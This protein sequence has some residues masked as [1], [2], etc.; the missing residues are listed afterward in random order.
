MIFIHGEKK[1]KLMMVALRHYDPEAIEKSEPD[2]FKEGYVV[3]SVPDAPYK[4]GMYA[5][6]YYNTETLD[7]EYEYS[8]APKTEE[9]LANERFAQLQKDNAELRQAVSELSLVMAAVM[10]GGE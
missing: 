3:E 5:T 6:T 9:E 7:F 8:P 4:P 10:G 1:R 2:V